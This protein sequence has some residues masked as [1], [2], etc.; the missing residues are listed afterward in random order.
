MESMPASRYSMAMDQL[1]QRGA[2]AV[3]PVLRSKPGTARS[4]GRHRAITPII[5]LAGRGARTPA[6]TE[7]AGHHRRA[8]ELLGA[9]ESRTAYRRRANRGRRR[10]K[11]TSKE[12]VFEMRRRR[13]QRKDPFGVAL[14]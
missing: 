1:H 14:P 7:S 12:T 5:R 11:E 9:A 2:A 10:R 8:S 4:A 6:R 3:Q 13:K